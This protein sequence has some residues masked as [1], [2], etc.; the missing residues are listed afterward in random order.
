[1]I[2]VLDNIPI[3]IS[4]EEVMGALRV[5]KKNSSIDG[6]VA[7]LLEKAV[8][9]ARPKALYKIS[10]ID[11]KN[12][13]TVTIDGV[14]FSSRILRKNLENVE[15]VFPYVATAGRELE[16]IALPKEDFMGMFCFDAIKE[17]ILE[18]SYHFLEKYIKEKYA[19]GTMAHMNPGSLSDW[20]VS[21]QI[22]LFSLF[23][24]VEGLIG[25]TLTPSFLMNP[26]K[27]VSGIY[28]PTEIDFKS[29]MLCPRHPCSKR[30]AEYNPEMVK[31]FK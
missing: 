12:G 26:I 30:R 1:M 25:V 8:K 22:P 27:S 16:N 20:P 31:K 17:L 24:D 3:T 10:Y 11:R 18:S 29:C 21:Q 14:Q 9:V 6:T 5:S 15:R 19:P 28:F 13:D 7:N 2:K 4:P 23:G